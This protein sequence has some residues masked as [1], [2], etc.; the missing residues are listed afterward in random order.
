VAACSGWRP[1]RDAHYVLL[2]EHYR[3]A[4]R[5][6]AGNGYMANTHELQITPDGIAYLMAY[7]RV[8][9][10]R[11]ACT[12]SDF[13]FQQVDVGTG[14]VLFEWHALDHVPLSASYR[15]RP[16]DGRSW[17]YFHGNSIEP[18]APDDRTILVSA[19][20]TSAVYGIDA[21]TGDVRWT[22]GGK[23]DEA[24]IARRGARVQFCAQHDARRLPNGDITI[25]DNGGLALGNERSCPLHKA[26]A[27]QFRVD[28][29]TGRA[30]LVRSIPSGPSSENGAGYLVSAMGSARRQANGNT[31]IS[32]G[33]NA[34]ITEVTPGGRVAFALRLGRYTY[35]TVRSGWKGLPPGRPLVEA[36]LRANGTTVWASWN[37]ATEVRRWRVLAGTSPAALRPVGSFG[38]VPLETRMEL[39][40]AASYLA[41]QAL[42][43]AGAVLGESQPERAR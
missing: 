17:D 4:A 34:R 36:R 2:D 23:L 14:D 10:P 31:L 8:R 30:R 43:S 15:P 3:T 1:H 7:E 29:K 19:R 39:G 21:V 22:L 40:M 35:R 12:V 16:T 25:F 28:R 9:D 20:N 24:G 11:C 41:V 6:R 5:I 26:R 38:F 42:D 27:Q 37:G 18:P 32:W 33:T 13:L